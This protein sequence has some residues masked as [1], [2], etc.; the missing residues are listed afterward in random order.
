MFENITDFNT[1]KKFF[2]VIFKIDKFINYLNIKLNILYQHISL[3][4]MFN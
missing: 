3:I 4:Y 2:Y 1:N